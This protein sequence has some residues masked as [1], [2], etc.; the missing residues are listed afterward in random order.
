M[1]MLKTI[2]V[3]LIPGVDI[4]SNIYTGNVQ[5]FTAP[6][7][8]T[9]KLE[10]WGAS[11]G[12]EQITSQFRA[13][14]GGYSTGRISLSL[15]TNLYIS[16]GQEGKT[17][18]ETV[19]GMGVPV[20][21]G[22]NGGGNGRTW[23]DSKIQSGGGGATSIQNSL[24]GDG[25]LK[26]YSNNK[27]NVIIVAGGGGGTGGAAHYSYATAS[28]GGD[29][30]GVCGSS[31]VAPDEG[32]IGT[33]GTQTEGGTYNREEDERYVITQ[34]SDFGVGQSIASPFNIGGTLVYG[35]SSGGGGGYYG[36]GGGAGAG[37]YGG[38]GSG[39]IGNSLLTQKYM[40]IY[41]GTT[42]NDESTKTIQNAKVS[43]TATTDYAK[44]GN[45]YCKITWMPVL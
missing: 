19:V 31:A 5:T 21:G 18:R 23:V 37:G 40:V 20:A 12:C 26:N 24:I 32:W 10:V 3:K 27:N 2:C 33:G 28:H 36:G 35:N 9:Y 30:G 43:S 7:A 41:S 14:Y 39:Y 1:A 16:V 34:I 15:S 44:S 8:T 13:G 4:Q 6:S 29:G 17:A 42:S 25:Q 11:G 38:G 22:W 45:G